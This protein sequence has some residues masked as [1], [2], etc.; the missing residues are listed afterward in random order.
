MFCFFEKKKTSFF[1]VSQ[2][3]F[4]RIFIFGK[5]F[6]SKDFF[7]KRLGFLKEEVFFSFFIRGLSGVC[8][9]FQWGL[10]LLFFEKMVFVFFSDFFFFER[11]FFFERN[12]FFF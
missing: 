7:F 12:C 8:L 2:N 5:V 4:R 9:F 1:F 3:F 11:C 6:F 10:V